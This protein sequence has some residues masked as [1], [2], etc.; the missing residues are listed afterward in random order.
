MLTWLTDTTMCKLQVCHQYIHSKGWPLWALEPCWLK[1]TAQDLELKCR[2]LSDC[3]KLVGS[4]C[5]TFLRRL[6]RHCECWRRLPVLTSVSCSA[7]TC[8]RLA[9]AMSGT[10]ARATSPSCAAA[11]RSESIPETTGTRVRVQT[12]VFEQSVLAKREKQEGILPRHQPHF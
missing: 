1:P 8:S 6:S 12:V 11:E 4:A 9:T 5:I 7:W 10:T 2:F 3:Q